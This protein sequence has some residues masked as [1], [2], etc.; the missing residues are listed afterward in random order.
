MQFRSQYVPLADGQANLP[1]FMKRLREIDYDGIVSLH[2]EYKGGSSFRVL[3]SRELLDQSATD[4][5]YLQS[6]TD[7]Q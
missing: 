7:S 3:N 4:L 6:L 2:S 1:R 5:R